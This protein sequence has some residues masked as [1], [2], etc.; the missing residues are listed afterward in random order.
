VV[1]ERLYLSETVTVE[2]AVTHLSECI[3]ESQNPGSWGSP[4]DVFKLVDRYLQWVETTELRLTSLTRDPDV[5]TMLLTERH[6]YIRRCG[7]SIA[8]PRPWPLVEAEVEAQ[9]RVLNRLLQDLKERS[10][11]LSSAPGHVT[12]VDTNLLFHFQPPEQIPWPEVLG[13]DLVRLVVPLRVVEELDAKKYAR[14]DDLADR[15]RRLLSNLEMAVGPNGAP[16]Q[17]RDRV[18]IEVPVDSGARRRPAD[19][20]QEI[21]DAC[22]E[23]HQLTG[24]GVTLVTGDTAMRL[25][26]QACGTHA[27]QLSPEFQR[28]RRQ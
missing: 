2:Q 7:A 10:T 12:V 18:T 4:G 11:R 24:R 28:D 13:H 16:G 27:T 19:A 26:A 17:L 14:R 20:D 23:M 8:D 15:A 9:R 21:L 1:P 6:W 3:R 25:R 22:R 5:S